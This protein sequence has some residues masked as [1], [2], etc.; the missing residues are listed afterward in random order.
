MTVRPEKKEQNPIP[1]TP[2]PSKQIK[3]VEK[4]NVKVEASPEIDFFDDVIDD[5]PTDDETIINSVRIDEN[6]DEDF[7]GAF[8]VHEKDD[9]SVQE[10]SEED[11]S[12][13]SLPRNKHD[14]TEAENDTNYENGTFSSIRY[15]LYI[16]LHMLNIQWTYIVSTFPLITNFAQNFVNVRNLQKDLLK[17]ELVWSTVYLEISI[18]N[19]GTLKFDDQWISSF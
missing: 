19:S 18:S 2:K 15:K 14:E 1:K 9:D 5:T 7:E 6:Y 8:E 17:S 10:S 3:T 12:E 11:K 13:S 4:P 16:K